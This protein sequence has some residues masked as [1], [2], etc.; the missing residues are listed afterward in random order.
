MGA[1]GPGLYSND[2]GL[3]LRSTIRAISRLPF[4]SD[5]LLDVAIG[6]ARA[7]ATVAENPDYATFWL[8]VADQ[9]QKRGIENSRALETALAII[10]S[11]GDATIMRELG[12]SES[13]IRKRIAK[14]QELRQRLSWSPPS[15]RGRVLS[16]PRAFLMEPGDIFAFATHAGVGINPY[17]SDYRGHFDWRPDAWSA[18]LVAGRGRAFGYLPW[19]LIVTLRDEVQ[20]RPSLEAVRDKAWALHGTGTCATLHMKRLELSRWGLS[21]WTMIDWSRHTERCP[22]EHNRLLMTFLYPIVYGRFRIHRGASVPG[23]GAT[24]SACRRRNCPSCSTKLMR[25]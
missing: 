3:D 14:M 18:F 17:C 8:V 12:M 16:K 25:T 9:F 4:E 22:R 21:R 13:D 5:R 7:E 10:D 19:Y 6:T 15:P 24:S 1:W 23:Y 20:D 11:G 2:F